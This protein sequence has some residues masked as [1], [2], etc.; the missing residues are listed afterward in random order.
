VTAEPL[1]SFR[2]LV[3]T[4]ECDQMGHMNVQFYTHKTSEALGNVGCALGLT[5][6]RLRQRNQDLTPRADHIHFKREAHAGDPLTMVSRV[7]AADH[8]AIRVASEMVNVSSGEIAATFDTVLCCRNTVTGDTVPFDDD[9]LDA[10]RK[11]IAGEAPAY[12]ATIAADP[13]V[14]AETAVETHRGMCNTWECDSQG[15]V[16]PRFHIARFSDAAGH[17]FAAF[18]L[19]GET[20]RANNWGM[21]AL[22]YKLAYRT[23]LRAGDTVAV[24]TNVLELANK[25]IRLRHDLVNTAAD[26]VAT[27]IEIV[28]V[29]FDTQARRATPLSD[30]LRRR[31]KDRW[32]DCTND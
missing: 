4:W 7:L 31:I 13:R 23:P 2:G 8:D 9:I 17:V 11:R 6:D 25:A 24:R 15:F 1:V 21:A 29:L 18:G 3:N 22:E 27:T 30:D 5:A 32:P 10:A 12:G 19:T 14:T 16:T 26:T 28:M 20:L